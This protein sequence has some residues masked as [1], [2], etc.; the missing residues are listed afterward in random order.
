ML[1]N[2]IQRDNTTQ[3]TLQQGGRGIGW[4][5][6][7]WLVT[8]LGGVATFLGLFILFGDEDQSVGLGGDFAWTVGEISSTWAY[9]LLTAG[10]VGLA[11]AATMTVTGR[12]MGPVRTTPLE[13]LAF[14][15]GV[16]VLVNAFLWAQ[17]YAL[18]SGLDYAH[19]V[20]IPWTVGLLAH[21]AT[22]FKAR[23]STS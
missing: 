14:H 18:G 13:D 23:S 1:N 21:A 2:T 22:A 15:T 17:D 4:K 19:Y 5:S 9:G 8:M 10:I 11:V 12:R 3:R 7:W 6:A 20:T 16:F